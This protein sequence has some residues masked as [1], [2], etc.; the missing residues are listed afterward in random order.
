[1]SAHSEFECHKC[2]ERKTLDHNMKT[3]KTKRYLEMIKEK[4][5]TIVRAK[6]EKRSLKFPCDKCDYVAARIGNL[7]THKMTKHEGVKFM[8]SYFPDYFFQNK[9]LVI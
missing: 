3:V 4:R 7:K 6:K 9:F 8:D 1:M 2:D 5:R